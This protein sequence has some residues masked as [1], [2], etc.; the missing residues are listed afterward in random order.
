MLT[1]AIFL[2][3]GKGIQREEGCRI[4]N[5]Y[6]IRRER[7]G[8]RVFIVIYAPEVSSGK[9]GLRDTKIDH[10]DGSNSYACPFC[11]GVWGGKPCV[12]LHIAAEHK[13]TQDNFPMR[14]PICE[15]NGVNSLSYKSVHHFKLHVL[16][17]HVY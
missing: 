5:C 1:S 10:G 15:E 14:C 9:C 3:V 16:R 7:F 13:F 6:R 17:D 8:L 2:G 11:K 12:R 4:T